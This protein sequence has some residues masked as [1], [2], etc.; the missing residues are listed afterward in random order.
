LGIGDAAAAATVRDA[1]QGYADRGVFRGFSETRG[2]GGT[3]EFRFTWL[4]REPMVLSHDHAARTL[5]FK[6]LLPEVAR[7]S[8]LLAD[9]EALIK[10]RSGRTVVAHR[11]IDARRIGVQCVHRRGIVS[12]VLQVKGQHQAYAVQR[13]VNLVH[14][15]FTL[16]QV[17]YPEYLWESFGLPAE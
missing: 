5:T 7:A 4:T 9:V 12:L 8:P 1:L 14:E 2:R 11:R 17:S 3:Q 6:Q 15:I 13:G 16:L 10:G